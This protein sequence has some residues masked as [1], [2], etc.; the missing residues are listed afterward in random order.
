M[1]AVNRIIVILM[2]LLLICATI[3]V[4]AAPVRSFDV[5]A[6]FFKWLSATA[7]DYQERN[8]PLW[9]IGRVVVGAV[10]GILFLLL[11]WLECRRKRV[12]IIRA[13]KLE[14]GESFITVDSVS[15]RLAYTIDQLPDVVRAVPRVSRYGRNGLEL[16]IVLETSPEIDVPSK[17]E[18][19]LQ[20]TK[21]VIT[22]RMG[23]KLGKVQVKI[24]HA[25]Y[26][27]H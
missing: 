6:G 11:L 17:T 5:S 23:L 13:Q 16:D 7:Q 4:V 12:R 8:W 22:E 25:P 15:Q 3:L 9:T 21:E 27:K 24:R 20:V 14:G 19:V 2:V 10:I 18:E 26:P 1:N